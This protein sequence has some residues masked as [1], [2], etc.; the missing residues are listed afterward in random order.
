MP[1]DD[2]LLLGVIVGAKGIKGEVRVKTFTERPEDIA[3]YGAL[4]DAA[5]QTTYKLKVIGLSKGLPVVRIKGISDRN[6][7]E[8]LKGTEL[9]VSRSELPEV[10][11]EDEFYYADLVGMQAVFKDGES[12]GIIAGVHDFGA[13]DMLEIIPEGKAE[14]SSVLVPF[15]ME[16]VPEV[17]M[18]AGQV[19]LNLSDDFFDVPKDP[20]SQEQ[21]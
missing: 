3:A 14:S 6:Q 5:G 8:A 13:G 7:A 1:Q 10:S 11:D 18:A 9:Y 15:T 4:K 2:R 21:A 19:V 17:N 20:Q 12:F 16:M